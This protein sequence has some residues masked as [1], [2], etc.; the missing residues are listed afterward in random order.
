MTL[1]TGLGSALGVATETTYGT[2]VPPTSWFPSFSSEGVELKQE[3]DQIAG[4]RPD[5]LVQQDGLHLPTV[6]HGEGPLEIAPVSVGM[7][8]LLN[9]LQ[10]ATITPTGAGTAKTR[11]YPIGLTVPD[12]RSLSFTVRVPGVDGVAVAKRITGATV[13]AVTFKCDAKGHLTSS[14]TIHAQ[15][16][17][18]VTTPPTPTYPAAFEAFGFRGVTFE[19]DGAAPP[20]LVR[21]FEI[22]ITFGRDEERFG[23]GGGGLTAAPLTNELI[24]VTVGFTAEF[25]GTAEFDA[26]K[27]A[28]RRSLVATF[29]GQNEI[30]TGVLPSIGFDVP[31]FVVNDGPTPSASGA[32]TVT[33]K[34]QGDVLGSA[35]GAPATITTVSTD[36]A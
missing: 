23:L 18:V 2:F 17:G 32:G 20:Q 29:S 26:F 24:K 4:L 19:V 28:D 22:T 27:A 9:V 5:V 8:P 34:V 35:S 12:G 31:T 33:T 14:W 36:P 10:G 30:E 25:A 7:H 16:I 3:F 21:D 6:S 1:S 15:D 11:E 13:R